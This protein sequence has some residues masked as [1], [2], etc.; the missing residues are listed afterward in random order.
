MIYGSSSLLPKIAGGDSEQVE[1]RE[2]P[3]LGEIGR[4]VCA[5]LN[6]KGGTLIVGIDSQGRVIGVESPLELSERVQRHLLEKLSPRAL[7]SIDVEEI[8]RK[9]VIIIDAPQGTEP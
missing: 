1:L 7:W 3:E 4:Y 2:A 5:F 8:D 9:S 6:T